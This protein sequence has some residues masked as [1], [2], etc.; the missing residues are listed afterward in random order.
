MESVKIIDIFVETDNDK[1]FMI[2]IPN[3][4]KVIDLEAIII[5]NKLNNG[6]FKIL[7]KEKNIQ[8]MMKMNYLILNN[9][10]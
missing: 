4:I 10:I 6:D 8:R 7:Y 5:K 2:E 9:K 3:K 1:R